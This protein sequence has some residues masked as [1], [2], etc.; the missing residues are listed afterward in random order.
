MSFLPILVTTDCYLK[1]STLL[2]HQ[3][4]GILNKA[5]IA[6]SLTMRNAQLK[7]LKEIMTCMVVIKKWVKYCYQ[8][9]LN[10][11]IVCNQLQYWFDLLKIVT[12]AQPKKDHSTCQQSCNSDQCL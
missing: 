5:M 7:K 10:Q 8:V 4:F 11:Q 9:L 6:W 2:E 12:Y 3:I 1:W